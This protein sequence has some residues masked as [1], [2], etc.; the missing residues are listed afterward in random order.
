VVKGARG[1]ARI[2]RAENGRGALYNYEELSGDPLALAP[3]RRSL[4]E[5]GELDAAGF[6][7]DAAWFERTSDHT[8]PDAPANLFKSLH[9]ERVRHTADVLVSLS[10]GYYYGMSFFSRFVSLLAT[11][12]NALRSSTH[13]FLMSTHR[14][15][16][17]HVRA[18]DA[19][20]HLRG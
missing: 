13:A 11:H 2:T 14:R 19:Q 20:P 17:A 15:F 3:V 7:S 16:P 4:I 8:Y 18:D 12:G 9:R 1:A 6:A 10:D 5:A